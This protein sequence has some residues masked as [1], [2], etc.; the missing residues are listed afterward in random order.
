MAAYFSVVAQARAFRPAL[1]VLAF[2][3]DQRTHLV[4]VSV[5]PLSGSA[6]C[7]GVYQVCE[8]HR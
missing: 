6:L 3:P 1:R 2:T 7:V 4:S 8:Q 5:Q